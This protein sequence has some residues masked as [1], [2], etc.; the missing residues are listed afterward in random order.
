MGVVCQKK[1]WVDFLIFTVEWGQKSAVAVGGWVHIH[2]VN[3]FPGFFF[4]FVPLLILK[5]AILPP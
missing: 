5:A 4:H 2:D 3:K 1:K